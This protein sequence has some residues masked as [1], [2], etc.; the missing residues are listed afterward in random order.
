MRGP[1]DAVQEE[2]QGMQRSITTVLV[3]AST[4]GC[5]DVDGPNGA[6]A[7]EDGTAATTSTPAQTGTTAGVPQHDTTTSS[8]S[9][10]STE[11]TASAGSSSTS[12]ADDDGASTT[13]PVGELPHVESFDGPNGAAWPEPW[14][15]AGDQII[16]S[17]LVDGRGR[18]DGQTG[19]VARMVLPGFSEV[20]VDIVV[21]VVFEHWE[22]QGFGLYVR[23]NGGALLQTDPPG[24][25]YAAYVEG[26]FMRYLGIWRETDGVEVPLANAPVP[27]GELESG[28]PYRLR[29]QCFG[30]DGSTRLRARLWPEG[31]PEPAV[32]QIEHLDDTPVLQGTPGSFAVDLYN[33]QG[34]ASVFVDDLYVDRM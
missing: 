10:A 16:S 27:D 4:L 31:E 12:A 1:Q 32:W 11:S 29:F 33:Y 14:E 17:E 5:S 30:E 18:F 7:A 8:D 2:T 21:T 13:A 15:E 25:G 24:Q 20:D 34:T 22:S 19:D 26:G 3:L 23:Q 28:V 6:P 9:T